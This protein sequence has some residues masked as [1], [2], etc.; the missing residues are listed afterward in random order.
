[1]QGDTPDG[2]FASVGDA[3]QPLID[4]GL[5]WMHPEGVTRQRSDSEGARQAHN[6]PTGDGSVDA[7]LVRADDSAASLE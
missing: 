5:E 1:M 2:A 6:K 4:A 3:V 7:R